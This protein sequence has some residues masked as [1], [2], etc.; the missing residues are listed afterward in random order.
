MS[1]GSPSDPRVPTDCEEELD[2]WRDCRGIAI[3]C[4]QENDGRQESY[5][6]C[7]ARRASC[8][9][10]EA[11]CIRQ[12]DHCEDSHYSCTEECD[13][14]WPYLGERTECFESCDENHPFCIDE[15]IAER[16]FCSDCN[17]PELLECADCGP[18]PEC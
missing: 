6:L 8:I 7:E 17:E 12:Y 3:L 1:H 5:E 11:Q 2:E 15:S 14:I 9:S 13:T 4:E 18:R 10:Q 16:C